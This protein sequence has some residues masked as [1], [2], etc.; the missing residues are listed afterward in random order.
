M[1][2]HKLSQDRTRAIGV[3]V[4][5][6]RRRLSPVAA[7]IGSK[8]VAG[9]LTAGAA[10]SESMFGR[11]GGVSRNAF[12]EATKILEGKG[13]VVSRQGTGTRVAEPAMW[14]MLDPEVMAWR[15]AKGDIDTFVADFFL[16]RRLI[17][18]TAAELA[19]TSNNE[20]QITK[21]SEAFQTMNKLEESEPFS[22]KYVLADVNFHKSILIASGNEFLVSMGN[23]LEVPMLLLFSLTTDMELGT[24]YRIDMHQKLH[25]EIMAKNPKGARRAAEQML[26]HIADDVQHVIAGHGE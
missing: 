10:L 9:T 4:L 24:S 22:E 12:R 19:A 26:D 11:V 14:N 21:I 6:G 15:I 20:D 5:A 8:I 3:A 7:E 17:E 18:P 1:T 23:L 13:L 25:D 16:F 2:A